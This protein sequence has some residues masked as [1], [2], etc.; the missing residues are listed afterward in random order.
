MVAWHQSRRDSRGA[1]RVA[2]YDY[3]LAIQLEKGTDMCTV[4]ELMF[5][6]LIRKFTNEGPYR[7][8]R[9]NAAE[10]L[11]ANLLGD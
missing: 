4:A 2:G 10:Q 5:Q 9:L 3:F 1:C 8:A 7:N 6:H 11:L